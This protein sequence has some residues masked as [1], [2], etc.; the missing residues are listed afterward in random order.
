MKS[1]VPVVRVQ[2]VVRADAAETFARSHFELP[3]GRFLFLAMFDTYSVLERKNPLAVLRAYKQAFPV[4]GS[5]TGL[6]LKFNNPNPSDPVARAAMEEVVERNDVFV[7]DRVFNRDEVISLV[8]VVDCFVSLHRSEGFGLSPAE[9]MYLGKPVVLTN[10]SG[11]TDYMTRD[12]SAA[13]DYKLVPLGRDY[14]PYDARQSWAE[15]D[16]ASAAC[17]MRRLFEEPGLARDMGARGRETI[18]NEFSPEAAGVV[19]ARRLEYIRR[20]ALRLG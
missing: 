7:I 13:V 1:P 5:S 3:E 11:N 19:V 2:P 9:A 6:V 17:W 10:W 8:S 4:P 12:N 16:E 18:K 14:G 20:F 15:P